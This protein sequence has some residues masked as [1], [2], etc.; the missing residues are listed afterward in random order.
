MPRERFDGFIE[1]VVA[2]Y[3]D[4]LSEAGYAR[5]D[6]AVKKSRDDTLGLLPKGIDTPGHYFY[7]IRDAVAR[8]CVGFAWLKLN[9]E[10]R[11]VVFIFSLAIEEAYRGRGYGKAAMAGIEEVSRSMGAEAIDLHVFGRN[12]RAIGLYRS[13][14]Y[15]V[16]S[17]NMGK[18]LR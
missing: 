5:G 9:E 16:R 8:E 1:E 7:V 13:C 12:E 18:E 14:G 11:K 3:A 15:E 4:E 17:L 6:A 10:P 2:Q